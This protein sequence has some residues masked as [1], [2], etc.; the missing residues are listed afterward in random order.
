MHNSDLQVLPM[1]PLSSG[2]IGQPLL[3]IALPI[4]I[5]CILYILYNQSSHIYFHDNQSTNTLISLSLLYFKATNF[6]I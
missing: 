3:L 4:K 6:L 2:T 5:N 1:A